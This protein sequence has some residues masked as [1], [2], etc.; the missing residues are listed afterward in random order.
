MSYTYSMKY[1]G[2]IYNPLDENHVTVVVKII[3]AEL[4][5]FCNSLTVIWI[6]VI[7]ISI[8]IDDGVSVW[9]RKSREYTWTI[10]P[11]LDLS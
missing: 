11:H 6:N 7:L 5:V 8:G 3:R 9:S 10:D 1:L 2:A 4:S